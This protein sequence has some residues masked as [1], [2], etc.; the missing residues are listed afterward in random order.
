MT[1]KKEKKLLSFKNDVHNLTTYPW[2]NSISI[3]NEL[4]ILTHLSKRTVERYAGKVIFINKFHW[5]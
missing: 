4:Q 1:K 3:Q 2:Y 5:H